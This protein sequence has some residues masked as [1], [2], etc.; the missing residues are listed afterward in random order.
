[1]RWWAGR[2]RSRR[3]LAWLLAV[4]AVALVAAVAVVVVWFP[5]LAAT[6]CPGCYG[7]ERVAPGLHAEPG[8]PASHRQQV[9]SAV[10]HANRRVDRFYGGRVSSPR[11]LACLTD[12][13][14]RRIGGGRERG[15]AVLNSAVMLSPRGVDP[16]IASH[17][18]SHVEL[19]TRLH[20][21]GARVPQWF[22]EGLAVLVSDDPRHLAPATA[23][24]R[25][26][27][28]AEG[29]LPVTLDDWLKAAAADPRTYA[30]AACRV[31]GWV[32]AHGGSHAVLDLVRRLNAGEE[33]HAVTGM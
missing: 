19:H 21:E 4:L 25:C 17:E 2:S 12:D 22:D 27:V 13:C 9:I 33:F 3:I 23:P 5:S 29:P 31:D 24:D 10:E 6:T 28:P 11:I 30:K 18:M 1:M 7:L 20:S 15:I 32:T 14:Y 8:P 26:L 16:V